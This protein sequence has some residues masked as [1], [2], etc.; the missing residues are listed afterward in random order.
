MP[1][2]NVLDQFDA[3]FKQDAEV[4]DPFNEGPQEQA[5]E[6]ASSEE[7]G[8]DEPH[9]NRRHRRLEAKLQSEREANI[10]LNARLAAISESQRFAH[11]TGEIHVDDS[12]LTLYGADENG[13]KAAEITQRLLEKTK[14]EARQEAIEE[15]RNQQEQEAQEFRQNNET[16][17]SM[18]EQ[19]E[20]EYDV[21]LTSDAP[22][23]RKARQQFLTTLG[24]LSPKDSEGLVTDYADALTTWEMVQLQQQRSNTTDRAKDLGSRSMVRSGASSQSKIEASAAERFLKDSGI[25]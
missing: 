14:N 17:D 22:S 3:E 7:G 2:D 5:P 19:V 6:A 1:Q 8:Q 10:A 20:D 9:K 16:L 12:L 4:N 24:R 23:A 13:R 18:L 25:I 11:D 15:F 21:D